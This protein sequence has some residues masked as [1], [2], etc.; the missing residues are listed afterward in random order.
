MLYTW[1]LV[2][3]LA[4]AGAYASDDDDCCSVEDKKEVAH[5]WHQI[6]HSS[7]T[8][9]K[10]KIM[11]AVFHELAE[12]HPEARE[13][14]KKLH[15][16]NEDGPEMRAY[17]IRITQGFDT[18]INLLEEPLVLEEQIDYLADKFGARVGLHK[19]YFEAV[20]DAFENVLPHVSSCFNV[21]AWNRCLRR[22]A[23][24]VSA[25]VKD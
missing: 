24:A 4:V 23:H 21:G 17:L 1:L 5:M 19:S 2:A 16:E 14:L 13:L 22:L 15:I 10:V 12:K 18:L 6:W 20:A 7:H 3:A 9:R 11:S 25:K 8:D